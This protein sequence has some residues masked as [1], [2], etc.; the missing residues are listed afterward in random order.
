MGNDALLTVHRLELGPVFG[1]SLDCAFDSE[2][3]F[4]GVVEVKR[5][6]W[7]RCV[8]ALG[9][10]RAAMTTESADTG[11]RY[12]GLRKNFDVDQLDA[13]ALEGFDMFSRGDALSS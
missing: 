2:R 3:L 4:V 8:P 6:A 9:L 5:A 11:S 13:A 1:I 7:E 10:H 12:R